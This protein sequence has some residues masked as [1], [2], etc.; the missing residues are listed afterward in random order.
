M[1]T[2]VLFARSP[3][4]RRSIEHADQLMASPDFRVLKSEAHTRAGF[5]DVSGAGPAFIKRVEVPSWRRGIVARLRG[6]RANRSL[7][8]AA[9]LEAH[10]LAHAQPLAAMDSI[11]PALSAPLISSATRSSTPIL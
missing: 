10:G 1:R 8:G 9:M 2:V 11:R 3:R 4:W 6:S 5:L 7:A